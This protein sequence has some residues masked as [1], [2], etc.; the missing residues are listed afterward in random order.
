[1]S[2]WIALVALVAFG[3]LWLLGALVLAF[4]GLRDRRDVDRCVLDLAV[5][6]SLASAVGMAT[7]A[8][9]GRLSLIPTYALLVA[10]AAWAIRRRR[11][12][13][14]RPVPPRD[15][16]AR[17]LLLGTGALSGL[18]VLTSFRD[19]LWWD[20][21]AIWG[22]KARVLFEAGTLPAPL[23]D[24]AGAYAFTHPEYPLGL[25]IVVWWIFRH[26]GATSPE[27]ISLAGSFWFACLPLLVWAGLR[28]RVGEVV[29]A[30]AAL[31]VTA[32]WPLAFYARGGTA[33]VLMAV[34]LL[35]AVVELE[36]GGR[37]PSGLWGAGA[38]LTLGAVAKNEGLAL[39]LVALGAGV[40]AR[41]RLGPDRLRIAPLLLPFAALAPWLIFTRALG[42]HPDVVHLSASWAS[43]LDRIPLLLSALIAVGSSPPWLPVSVLALV[44]CLGASRHRELG[45]NLAWAVL[46]GYWATICAVYLTAPH[47]ARWLFLTSLPR[48]GATLVPAVVYLSLLG[49]C[50]AVRR[51]PTGAEEAW[52]HA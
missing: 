5:G 32:F 37:D 47:D 15:R 34:A 11:A 18:I 27:L 16:R 41:V 48:V 43:V 19:L 49:A 35:G 21:W 38:F 45:L 1:M 26:A 31:G 22:F 23:L 44:G 29:A 30:A 51:A 7:L 46:A 52:A 33:D 20:G 40:I 17:A 6:T 12:V 36:R 2:L 8:L 3:A 9:G 4:S 25:P 24:P 39:A 28:S 13:W 42:L 14:P 10:L 50:G